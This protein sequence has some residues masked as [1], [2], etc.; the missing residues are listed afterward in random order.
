[1]A[2]SGRYIPSILFLSRLTTNGDVCLVMISRGFGYLLALSRAFTVWIIFDLDVSD[3]IV[4]RQMMKRAI[5]ILS[6]I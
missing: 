2:I 4:G 6:E 3:D 5:Q 1:M